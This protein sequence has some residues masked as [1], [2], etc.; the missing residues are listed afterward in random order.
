MPQAA[1]VYRKLRELRL[2]QLGDPNADIADEYVFQPDQMNR[3]YAYRKLTRQFGVILHEAGLKQTAD[4]E[5]RTLYSLRHTSLMYRI[6]YGGHIDSGQLAN[7]ARTS[8]EMLERFY[9]SRMESSH[10][11]ERLHA[12]KERKPK[13]AKSTFVTPANLEPVDLQGMFSKARERLPKELR[14]KPLKLGGD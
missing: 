4:N 9:L 11:T 3:K 2:A 8:S 7:N 10:Y 14:D 5:S 12:K 6:R 1:L 13:K